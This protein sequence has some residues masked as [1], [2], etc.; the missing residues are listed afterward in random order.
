MNLL[1]TLSAQKKLSH[2]QIAVF[3]ELAEQGKMNLV[4]QAAILAGLNVKGITPQELA[5][6][7]KIL[8]KKIPEKVDF[9]G[10][11]DI[12]GTGGSGLDRINTSTISAFVLSALGVKIAKHG[13]RAASGRFGSFDLLDQLGIRYDLSPKH[14]QQLGQQLHLNFLYARQFHPAVKYFSQVRQELGFP[15]VFNLLGPLLNPASTTIQIIGTPFRHQMKII[16]GTAKRLGKKR[17]MV[18]CGEDGLD[19]VTLTGKTFVT[20]LNRGNIRSYTITPSSFGISSARF[21]DITGGNAKRNTDIALEILK[22][23]CK[24]RHL[25]LVLINCALALK[26]S[27][28]TSNLKKAYQIAKE[29]VLNGKA[30]HQFLA[31]KK[32]THAPSVLLEI[33]RNTRKEVEQRKR[34]LPLKKFLKKLQP[35]E[36]DF[37]SALLGTSTT[38]IAEIK[39]SSPSEGILRKGKFD[40]GGIAKLYES[41]GAKA[42][43]V[44]TDKKFFGGDLQNLRKAQEATK[45]TPLLRKDFIIDEYQIYEARY[46]GADAI[47][48]IAGILTPEEINR[49]IAI[50][51][52]YCMHALVEVHTEAELKEVLTT[53]AE[54]IGINNRDLHTFKTDLKTTTKLCKKIPQSKIVVAESGIHS[55]QQLLR[56]PKKV[57]SV[58]IGTS[59]MKSGDLQKKIFELIGKPKPLV[60]ICGVQS[61]DEALLCQKYG[62]NLVGLNFVPTSTRRISYQTGANITKTLL[63]RGGTKVVGVFQNQSL[64]EVNRAA[65][66]IGLDYIQLSGDE[67]LSYLK[68]CVR[69][70]IKGISIVRKNSLKKI[71]RYLGKVHLVLLDGKEP[72]S[73]KAFDHRSLRKLKAPFILAGGMSPDNVRQTLKEVRP[74][75]VDVASGVESEGK[76]DFKKIRL[77][78]QRA[79]S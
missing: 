8:L 70:V 76:R 77:F 41:S 11:L 1:Q 28:V 44:L 10:A 20:E 75:G 63:Q 14:L 52:S 64:E 17:V 5:S 16:A 23:Q 47:L 68:R 50:A 55:R 36:R 79:K 32:A 61:V 56:L 6:F 58:L 18:V 69:P 49:F 48:L 7:A 51:R 29:C 43:S 2:E 39:R 66:S 30:Y 15:T 34:K 35:S 54:I 31:Y 74:T 60:K 24:S 25:D 12:C 27:G 65:Q 33:V 73:G 42:I 13:N 57:R 78:L 38:L 37:R 9:P 26:I 71:D 46:F 21:E 22:G 59:L 4:Q 40:V 67:P 45:H 72:G 3:I 19:E 62:A 53:D